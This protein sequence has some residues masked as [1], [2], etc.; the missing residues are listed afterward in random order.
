MKNGRQFVKLCL[1]VRYL[2][3]VVPLYLVDSIN[4]C[5]KAWYKP[6]REGE[7]GCDKLASNPVLG[8]WSWMVLPSSLFING[9]KTGS[10]KSKATWHAKCSLPYFQ[11]MWSVLPDQMSDKFSWWHCTAIHYLLS[12]AFLYSHYLSCWRYINIVLGKYL[13]INFNWG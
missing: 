6:G 1:W 8:E 7:D 9:L 11:L 13:L 12:D 5:G 2:S 3:T 4:G 10:T